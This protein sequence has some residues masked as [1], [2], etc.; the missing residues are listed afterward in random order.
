M[1]AQLER[2]VDLLEIMNNQLENINNHLERLTEGGTSI[3]GK[4]DTIAAK[5][6]DIDN[7]VS[8]IIINS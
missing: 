1:E 6:V 7:G 5:L 2:I 3:G 4:L 8:N